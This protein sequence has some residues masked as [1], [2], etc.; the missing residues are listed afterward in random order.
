MARS[1]GYELGLYK[2]FVGSMHL[3]DTDR[4]DAQRYLEEAVQRRIEMPPMPEGDPWPSIRKLL[5]AE[6]RVRNGETIDAGRW[7]VDTYWADLIRLL[8]IFA[9]TGDQERIDALKSAMAFKRYFPYI[10]GRRTMDP[11]ASQTPAQPSLRLL[12]L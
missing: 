2:H 1:L 6:Y 9:A 7:G 4:E 10:D 3:Y 5:D 12:I 8:Q 11:R